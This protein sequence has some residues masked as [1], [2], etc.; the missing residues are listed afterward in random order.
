MNELLIDKDV[1]QKYLKTCRVIAGYTAQ[2]FAD[3]LGISRCY[4]VNL[5]NGK[6]KM[7]TLHAYAIMYVLESCNSHRYINNDSY[8]YI[9]E[10]LC[11]ENTALKANIVKVVEP[12]T[13]PNKIPLKKRYQ[14]LRTE[15]FNLYFSRTFSSI[16]FT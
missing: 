15:L 16:F 5:E 12:Y 14:K 3:A 10:L 9:H 13:K 6:Q 8:R 1:L 4:L 7:D 2:E 11:T